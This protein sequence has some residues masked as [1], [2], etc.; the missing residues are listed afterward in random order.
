MFG[1]AR[2]G[3][4]LA[5]IAGGTLMAYQLVGGAAPLEAGKGMADLTPDTERL[6]VPLGGYGDRQ[7]AP[8]EGVHD[9]TLARALVFKRGE[10]R[11]ALVACDLL[12][13]PRSLR[14]EVV[15]RLEGTGIGS[16][17][18]MLTASHTH[19]SV[20][21]M[22][23]NRKNVFQN[24]A[25]GIFDEALLEFTADRI[26][27]A[28]RAAN[29]AFV[30]VRA[31]TGAVELPGMNRNRR[32]DG[33]TDDTMIVT[34][35]DTMAGAPFAVIVNYAAHPTLMGADVM[36][37]S[38]GWPGYLQRNI[39]G[40]WGEDALCLF[41]NGAVGDQSPQ[42]AQGPSPFARA[43]DY[44]RKLAAAA[45][46]LLPGIETDPEP[47]FGWRMEKVALPERT[48][49][50][51]LLD[52]AGPEYGLTPENIQFVVEALAPEDAYFS[53]LRIGGLFALAIPG[54][55]SAE[56]GI[57]IKAALR[58][59]GAPRP[60]IFGLGNEWISYMLTPA[61]YD[62]GGYEAGVSFYGREFGPF[63][64]EQALRVGRAVLGAAGAG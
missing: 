17:N 38:A 52:A 25:I 13:I 3:G 54:E 58:A 18:L 47:A 15:A 22:A 16:D 41:V 62:A 8:A 27:E 7:N 28:V 43:E 6:H 12:G 26:A 37:V 39:E 40:F 61:Q 59:E 1:S 50:P 20:E 30:P 48:P 64:A 14:E 44:G 9:S 34:R 2:G 49:P 21:M 23:M 51:A 46:R 4:L 11:F 42:G 5:A 63:V 32:G 19:A 55:L 31:G 10:D 60:A 36:V 29:A 35:I 57:E 53:A 56:I 45:L 24:K 33:P